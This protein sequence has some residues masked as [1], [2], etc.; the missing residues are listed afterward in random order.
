MNQKLAKN[1]LVFMF[2]Q[3]IGMIVSGYLVHHHYALESTEGAFQSFCSINEKIDC[4]VVNGSVYSMLFGIP[5]AAIGFGTYFLQLLLAFTIKFNPQANK[6]SVFTNFILTVVGV[7]Y[8]LFLFIVSIAVLKTTCIL[9][10]SLYV[11]NILSFIFN[12]KIL[13]EINQNNGI[14]S[15]YTT[16]D[17]KKLIF[18]FIMNFVAVLVVHGVTN[19]A[20]SQNLPFDKSEFLTDLRL[21]NPKN[22]TPGKSPILGDK[23]TNPKLQIIEF[24]DFECPHCMLAAK[25]MHRLLHL[26]G[27]KFQLIFKN[28]PLDDACNPAMKRPMHLNACK[29]AK[30]VLCAENSSNYL[31]Y[32]EKVFSNQKEI[33]AENLKKWAVELGMN[34]DEFEKCVQSPDTSRRIAE[35]IE[36][37]EQLGITS[38]PSF[39]VN[40]RKIEGIIDEQRFKVILE[41]VGK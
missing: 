39:F 18:N 10:M 20:F 1:N 8:S 33:N 5:I 31:K 40:G 21:Q 12:L 26:Y 25:Q 32:F 27:D 3:I 34:A 30:S 28:Y 2:L 4:N 29:A 17:R 9:C 22:I 23:S 11:I 37:A 38:T 35:D 7:L 13:K 6:E 14:L 36:A 19:I 16:L 24:A 41:E 15:L